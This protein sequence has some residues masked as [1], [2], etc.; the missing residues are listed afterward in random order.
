MHIREPRQSRSPTGPVIN[1]SVSSTLK[2][3]GHP[4]PRLQNGRGLPVKRKAL[5]ILTVAI[6]AFAMIPAIG[7]SADAGVVKIVTPDQL[8]NPAGKSGSDFNNLEGVEYVSTSIGTDDNLRDSSSTLYIVIDDNDADSNQLHKVTSV[9]D[10]IERG[11]T[12]VVFD[13]RRSGTGTSTFANS[14]LDA[15]GNPITESGEL[16]ILVVTDR[17]GDGVTDDRDITVKF[18][19]I[20][21]IA[22]VSAV[23]DTTV[24]VITSRFPAGT[25]KMEL[26]YSTSRT[27]ALVDADTGASLVQVRSDSGESIYVIASEKALD[28]YAADADGIDASD[29]SDDSAV[30]QDS[31]VFVGRVALISN[32]WKQMIRTWVTD[33]SDADAPLTLGELSIP[34]GA[35]DTVDG[36]V[37]GELPIPANSPIKI[38]GDLGDVNTAADDHFVYDSN[39]DGVINKLDFDVSYVRGTNSRSSVKVSIKNVAVADDGT[40]SVSLEMTGTILMNPD[41]TAASSDKILLKYKKTG[42]VDALLD[43]IQERIDDPDGNELNDAFDDLC[44]HSADNSACEDGTALKDALESHAD[45]LGISTDDTGA[46]ILVNSLIGVTDGDELEIRYDDPSSGQGIKRA[47][48]TVDT[49]APSIGGF[50]PAKD[51]FTTDDRFDASF[52]LT[53]AG[54]GVVDDGH[55]EGIAETQYVSVDTRVRQVGGTSWDSPETEEELDQA[56]GSVPDGYGYEVDIDVRDETKAAE[57]DDKNLQVELSVTA[58]DKARNKKSVTIVFTVDSTD[59]Q[60]EGAITGWGVAYK[61]DADRSSKAGNDEAGA[62]VL[63]ENQRNSIALVFDAPVNGATIRAADVGVGG[64]SVA[65]I[66]WL[67]Y[68]GGNVVSVGDVEDIDFNKK[69]ASGNRVRDFVEDSLGRGLEL[70]L[71]ASGQDARHILF[72]EIDSDLD[73]DAQPSI[74]IDRGD[75]EDLAGN[76]AGSLDFS[77]SHDGLYPKFAVAVADKLSNDTLSL[78][79]TSSE[80]LERAPTGKISKDGVERNLDVDSAG[81]QKWEVTDDRASLNLTTKSGANDGVWEI[82]LTGEDRGGNSITDISAEWELDTLANKNEAPIRRGSDTDDAARPHALERD[83]VVFLS[84]EFAAEGAEYTDD[85][86][87]KISI[88]KLTL[89]KLAA[90]SLS[91]T[92]KKIVANPTV[93]STTELEASTAQS[94]DGV[95]H[96]IALAEPGLGDY[97]LKV[98]FT[99][100]AGNTGKFDYV[101]SVTAPKPSKIAVVPG[102]SLISIPGRPLDRSVGG[103][104]KDSAV[105]DVWSLNNETKIWDFAR[106]DAESGEWMGTLTQIV[107]GRGYFVRSTT[108]DPVN[109]LIERF[110]P[111]RTPAQYAVHTGWNSVGYTPAGREGKVAVDAYLSSLGASGWGMIRTWNAK[112][113]PPQYE[114]YF[115]SGT[116]TDGFPVMSDSDSTAVVESG[117]GYLLFATRDGVIGG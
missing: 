105:T 100:V 66:T 53:D 99:D 77:R 6:L 58:Y 10:S 38:P 42:N 16:D 19:G 40:V 113:T 80:D 115:S 34:L 57:D 72:L 4:G 94:S 64:H 30:S 117:K 96:V 65:S 84:L 5:I 68:N 8:A 54:S 81:S 107:D 95:T 60:L 102:W 82:H 29:F 27:D 20:R 106:L 1:P 52:T 22:A 70:D 83:D 18:N 41:V 44:E 86:Q 101:L 69:T 93:E 39:A 103:V 43:A 62:Y 37:D 7:V 89:E 28:K 71:G 75:L 47:N 56:S 36:I 12:P 92:P 87:K 24:T 112:A 116:G 25:A 59:P 17:D 67:D 45:N 35:G 63:Q 14:V 74:Q 2:R 33:D 114:T 76:T 23:G 50:D 31:G 85:S 109:V 13:V 46:S 91:G 3:P 32:E 98:E 21:Q 79:I 55:E 73:T 78:E 48:A 108:F 104:L 9:Y 90:E 26:E 61:D 110:S 49:V 88:A 111:R 97:R 51:S 11:T 15:D